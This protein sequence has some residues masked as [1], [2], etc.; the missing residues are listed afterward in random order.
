MKSS[1]KKILFHPL[2]F[3]IVALWQAEVKD[4]LGAVEVSGRLRLR[5]TTNRD[6]LRHSFD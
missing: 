5:L 3:P 6:K 4:G 2:M 1:P